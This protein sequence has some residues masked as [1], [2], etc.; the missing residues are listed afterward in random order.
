MSTAPR[1]STMDGL[2]GVAALSVMLLHATNSLALPLFPSAYAAVDL[3]FCLSGFVIA[4]SY[5]AKL[6]AGMRMH[7]FL[8]LRIIRLYPLYALGTAIGG[9]AYLLLGPIPGQPLTLWQSMLAVFGVPTIGLT[10]Q[11]HGADVQDL[12]S[13]FPLNNPMWSLSLEMGL[14]ALFALW[15]P[16]GKA[17]LTTI[18]VSAAL[19]VATTISLREPCG[20]NANDFFA[21]FPRAMFSFYVGVWLYRA[22]EAGR[23]P[24]PAIG[25]RLAPL[26]AAAMFAPM[27]SLPTYLALVLVATPYLAAGA[28]E[29]PKS[30]R[31][32]RLYGLLGEISYPVY[33]I[34]LPLLRFV[35]AAHAR[36]LPAD[37]PPLAHLAFMLVGAATIVA[38][39]FATVR[40]YDA[41][42]RR[43]LMSLWRR[44][45]ARRPRWADVG[46]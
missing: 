3:F 9:V 13:V 39:A 34:H 42:V 31:L 25:A 18:A 7:E 11:P 4:L 8:A 27:F 20:S 10:L 45:A 5:G 38:V 16:R 36:L 14:C 12:G 40:C 29:Q 43:W 26:A 17:L 28:V 30:A 44:R 21:G 2:R 6:D 46:I 35:W 24:R 41:P 15:R 32:T 23:S 37:A 22:V 1:F 19:F 33:A